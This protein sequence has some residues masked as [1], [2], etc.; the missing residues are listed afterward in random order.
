MLEFLMAEA[1]V[2]DLHQRYTDAVWRRDFDAFANCFAEDAEWRISGMA[3]RGRQQI[4]ETFERIMEKMGRVLISFRAPILHEVDG[5]YCARTYIDERC[6][7]KNG[8]TNIALGCYYDRFVE[9][10]GH[11]FFQ[12]RLF[13]QLYRGAPDMTGTFLDFDDYGAPPAMPPLTA[14]TPDTARARWGL[15]AG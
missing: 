14:L 11:W 4:R 10:D 1:G 12:W 9:I 7:W 5:A 3:L 13:Q 15:D 2:R 8:D 6:A